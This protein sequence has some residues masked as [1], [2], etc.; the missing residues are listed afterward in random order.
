MENVHEIR[1]CERC[2]RQVRACRCGSEATMAVRA[3]GSYGPRIR[4]IRERRVV[5]EHVF[6]SEAVEEIVEIVRLACERSGA[7]AVKFRL[8]RS[9]A[10]ELAREEGDLRV[11]RQALLGED[12]SNRH[13]RHGSVKGTAGRKVIA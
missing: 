9:P 7:D 4:E 1:V 3:T 6:T 5:T 8:G 2:R 12:H 11:L 13:S 10:L